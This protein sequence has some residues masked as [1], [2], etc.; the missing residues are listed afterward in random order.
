MSY[1][2]GTREM[3]GWLVLKIMCQSQHSA[4]IFCFRLSL[5]KQ[6]SRQILAAVSWV[7][8]GELSTKFLMFSPKVLHFQGK[9]H[10]MT[11]GITHPKHLRFRDLQF[12]R[13]L[14]QPVLVVGALRE[15]VVDGIYATRQNTISRSQ[16]KEIVHHQVPFLLR[17]TPPNIGKKRLPSL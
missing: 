7:H 10:H 16:Q 2:E 15:L 11:A 3:I 9:F 6:L 5:S 17:S 14:H 8:L 12:R 4:G 1:G 13:S